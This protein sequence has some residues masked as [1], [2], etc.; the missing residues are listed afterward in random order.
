MNFKNFWV[1]MSLAG[2]FLAAVEVE[3]G[4]AF[5]RSRQGRTLVHFRQGM[6]GLENF[7]PTDGFSV[8]SH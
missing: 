4:P 7:L 2:F 8:L 3:K 6:L 5:S 1:W